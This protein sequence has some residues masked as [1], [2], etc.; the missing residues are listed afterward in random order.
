MEGRLGWARDIHIHI[1]GTIRNLHIMVN[2]APLSWRNS[3]EGGD[4]LPNY[5][6]LGIPQ[7]TWQ[8][9]EN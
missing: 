5:S 1:Q 8:Q 9:S 4:S 2:T 6:Q 3:K 7:R